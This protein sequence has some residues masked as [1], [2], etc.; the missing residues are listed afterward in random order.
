[1]NRLHRL[2]LLIYTAVGMS[3]AATAHHST[4]AYDYTKMMTLQGVV[5][6]FQWSNPHCYIQLLVSDA[7]GQQKEWAVET[8]TP[9][10]ST[11]LGWNKDS[12][13]AGDKV[14]VVLSP[15]RDGSAA[16]TLRT[17]TLPNGKVLP[18]AAANV[19]TDK[20]GTPDL[21]PQLPTLKPSSP[22]Q[23]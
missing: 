8:G 1:M 20:E 18:G 10:L 11:H 21:V 15:M 22:K 14:T 13:K 16:G 23:P 6:D 19:N 5:R 7:N 9:S 17:V 12:V 2:L 4:A 3:H